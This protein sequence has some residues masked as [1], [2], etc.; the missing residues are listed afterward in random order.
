MKRFKTVDEFM[1]SIDHWKPE[2]TRLRQ[3]LLTTSLEETTKWGSP[4]YTHKG[5]NVVGIGGFKSYFGLWFFQ[6]ALLPDKQNLL[7]NAQEG[8]TK[9]MRQWRM[10]TMKE[11]KP[12]ISNLMWPIR[13][14]LLMPARKLKPNRAK[15][16]VV[17]A[18]LEKA[19]KKHKRAHTIF[20]EFTIGKQRDFAE[21]VSDAKQ[22]ATK[23]KRIDKDF[24]HDSRRCGPE[25]QIQVK[26]ISG[27]TP[28]I[29]FFQPRAPN[30]TLQ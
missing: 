17:P 20:K 25:R 14:N 21:Y 26:S 4:C 24:A 7:V 6:G 23:S 19:F 27:R 15:P 1:K 2:I 10:Q 16:V 8:R 5:K 9:A 3:I 11:I 22:Q 18:E 12:T 30:G 13:S 28:F 29:V